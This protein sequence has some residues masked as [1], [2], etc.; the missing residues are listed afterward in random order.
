M[1][2]D[3]QFAFN[4]NAIAQRESI[5]VDKKRI[6]IKYHFSYFEKNQEHFIK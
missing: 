5:I 3:V 4:T 6:S 1:K 2:N